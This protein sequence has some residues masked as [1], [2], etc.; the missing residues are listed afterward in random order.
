[1]LAVACSFSR[2]ISRP[3]L[4]SP[5]LLYSALTPS[6]PPHPCPRRPNASLSVVAELR[7]TYIIFVRDVHDHGDVL[8]RYVWVGT[9]GTVDGQVLIVR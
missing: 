8:V 4:L 3:V 1:M 6:F 7:N 9:V 2:W 5:L